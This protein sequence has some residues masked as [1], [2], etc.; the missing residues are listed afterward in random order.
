LPYE[1][2]LSFVPYSLL[3]FIFGWVLILN[4]C[5]DLVCFDSR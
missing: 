1:I 3:C 2:F 4:H 5:I